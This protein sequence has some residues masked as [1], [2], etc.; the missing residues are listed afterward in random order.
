VLI[1]RNEETSVDAEGSTYSNV[2]LTEYNA[3]CATFPNTQQSCEQENMSPPIDDILCG[4][5]LSYSERHLLSTPETMASR[6]NEAE[7]KH[8]RQICVHF[9]AS[10]TSSLLWRWPL[11]FTSETGVP[12]TRAVG[13]VYANFDFSAFLCSSYEHAYGTDGR[14]ERR[15]GKTNNAAHRTA[16]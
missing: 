11:T 8:V 1:R 5:P 2:F 14:T 12:V 16:A 3:I 15:T 9:C 6:V 10:F 7:C 13:N 4:R